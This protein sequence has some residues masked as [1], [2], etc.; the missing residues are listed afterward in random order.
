TSDPV[1]LQIELRRLSEFGGTFT[2]NVTHESISFVSSGSVAQITVPN[3]LQQ[4]Y[5]WQA[6][7]VDSTGLASP[8]VQ[9]GANP[10]SAADFNVNSGAFD[11]SLGNSGGITVAAGRSGS[12]T[13]PNNLTSSTTAPVTPSTSRLT[14]HAAPPLK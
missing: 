2:Q 4:A 3:L 10:T 9:F 14:I 7:T 13:I 12:T 6:R 11:Y 8:W 1:K 5:H